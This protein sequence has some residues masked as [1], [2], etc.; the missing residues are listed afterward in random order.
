MQA[1]IAVAIEL[2][3]FT[4]MRIGNLVALDLEHNFRPGRN[5]ELIVVLEAEDVKNQ[6]AMECPVP[7]R[8]VESMRSRLQQQ[9]RASGCPLHL[10]TLRKRL[11][12]TAFTV[13]SAKHEE[14][15]SPERNRSASSR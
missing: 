6:E 1:Q 15:R 12:I 4:R 8:T 3:I 10:L 2:E 7:K 13:D 5:D 11:L 9:V 14:M